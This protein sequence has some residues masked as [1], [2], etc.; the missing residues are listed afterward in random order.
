VFKERIDRAVQI[1]SVADGKLARMQHE[2]DQVHVARRKAEA[3]KKKSDEMLQRE[4]QLK[5]E[6][7]AQMKEV[8][9]AALPAS[10]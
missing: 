6:C 4:L 10:D 2:F 3:A 1:K 8:C 9:T 7:E 5:K